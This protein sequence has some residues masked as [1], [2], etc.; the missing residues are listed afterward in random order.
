VPASAV[1]P[2]VAAAGLLLGAAAAGYDIIRSG[3]TIVRW[4]AG[5]VTMQVKVGSSRALTDGSNFGTSFQAAAADWNAQMARVQLV[6]NLAS[7]GPGGER[8]GIN[9]VFFDST[10]FGSAF[11]ASTLAVTTSFLSTVRQPDGTFRRTQSDI[12]FNSAKNWD[13]YRGPTRSATDFRRV[14]IHELGHV[15]GLDHPDETGQAVSAIMNS[16]VSSID[17]LQ[18]DDKDG[19]H[20]L[21]GRAGTLT[22]PANNDF[23]QAAP[24]VLGPLNSTTVT[25]STTEANKE[26]GEPNHAPGEVGG[27][28]VWW[29]WTASAE[30][31]LRVTTADSN[32]D[33]MLGAYTGATLAS[34]AQLASNDDEVTPEQDPTPTRPRTSAISFAA[35]AGKTYFLAVDG[36]SAET[37]TAKVNLTFTPTLPGPGLTAHP[38][39]RTV[40]LG[41]SAT[42]AVTVASPTNI[43]YQ[44]LRN[45]ESIAGATASTYTI[46]NA[47]AADAGLYACRVTNTF[48]GGATT[49]NTAIVGLDIP[50]RVNGAATEVGSDIRHPNGNFYDQYLLQGT[51]AAIRSDPGQVT[52]ISFIDLNDDIVQVEFSGAGTLVLQLQGATG[53]AVPVKYTQPTVSYLKGHVRILL[54]GADRTTNVSFF[55]VGRRTA[56]DPTGAFDFLAAVSATNVPAKNGSSLFGGQGATVYDGLADLASVAILS[57]TGEF[58]GVRMANAGFWATEGLAGIYAPGVAFSGPVFF[59]DLE[60]RS[61][62]VPVILL[63]SASDVRVTG[64]D[65]LQANDADVLVSGFSQLR[66]SSG[67]NSHG[68]ALAAQANRARLVRNGEDVTAAVVSG[69]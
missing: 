41:G 48:S 49:S 39:S 67:E 3:Q 31:T 6:A 43:A 46:T 62:A 59:G 22:R 37:G 28:S 27:A 16:R 32:F 54:S 29:R 44:W 23:A 2:L 61:T 12:V 24:V 36:W 20:F 45:G 35:R 7:E 60:A 57:A 21:Y 14:A 50:G 11:G 26:A 19:V 30:G 58:G 17:V 68:V 64:G 18:Q 42:L 15:L 33:T 40:A 53:P 1:R 51:A 9:E 47:A 56:F 38:A 5:N 8:N 13:S 69:P 34:L 52:R 63:G 55:S 10:I 66:F 25:G 4:P 65:L